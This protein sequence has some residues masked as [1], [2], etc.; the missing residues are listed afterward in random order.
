MPT[1][2]YSVLIL[3]Y[4]TTRTPV[5]LADVINFYWNIPHVAT[6]NSLQMAYNVRFEMQNLEE[7]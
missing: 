6:G 3:N 5:I 1:Y 7:K 2:S 4:S